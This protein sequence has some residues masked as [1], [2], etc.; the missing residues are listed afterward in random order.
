MNKKAILAGLV[1]IILI[2]GYAGT[3]YFYKKYHSVKE[4]PEAATTEENAQLVREVSKIMVLP[5]DEI[6]TVATVLDKSKV[7]SQ[8]FFEKA[9]NGDKLLAYVKKKQAILYRPSTHKIIEVAPIYPNS[10]PS[11]NTASST[12]MN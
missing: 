12:I 5:T 1:L 2:G 3:Y 4:N 11:S 8:P 10:E 6:P 9:E 7:N